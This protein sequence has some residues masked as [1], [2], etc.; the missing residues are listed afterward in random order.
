MIKLTHTI[1]EKAYHPAQILI[2]GTLNTNKQLKC[3]KKHNSVSFI[4]T[5][6]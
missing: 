1:I 5:D 3:D 4:F 6:V 2:K